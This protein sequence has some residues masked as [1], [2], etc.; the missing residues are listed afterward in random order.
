MIK[1]KKLIVKNSQIF[2]MINNQMN[3]KKI[4]VMIQI[5]KNNNSTNLKNNNL[6]IIFLTFK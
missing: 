6:K 1:L 4:L 5:D 3:L 2:K